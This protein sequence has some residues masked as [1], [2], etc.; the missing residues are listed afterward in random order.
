MELCVFPLVVVMGGERKRKAKTAVVYLILISQISGFRE[1]IE[2]TSELTNGRVWVW[3]QSDCCQRRV[4]KGREEFW[5]LVERKST[6]ASYPW[7]YVL[8]VFLDIGIRVAVFFGVVFSSGCDGC[9]G[10]GPFGGYYYRSGE[11]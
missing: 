4:I 10:G 2:V 9:D 8:K 1:R 3:I 5:G 6:E 11:R 7:M